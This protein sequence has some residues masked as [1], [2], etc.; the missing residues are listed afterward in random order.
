VFQKNTVED[1]GINAED[2]PLPY[3]IGARIF[4]LPEFQSL[5]SVNMLRCGILLLISKSWPQSVSSVNRIKMKSLDW[6]TSA[7]FFS[8]F[9][10]RMLSVLSSDTEMLSAETNGRRVIKKQHPSPLK[11]QTIGKNL[12][13]SC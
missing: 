8:P 7:G 10:V 5:P 3:I 6:V 12:L 1:Y 2:T 13:L 9:R 4:C 11:P